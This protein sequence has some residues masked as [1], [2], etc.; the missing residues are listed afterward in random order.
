MKKKKPFKVCIFKGFIK[1]KT[2][3]FKN[4][5]TKRCNMLTTIVLFIFIAI[6]NY[7]KI[8]GIRLVKRGRSHGVFVILTAKMFF[9]FSI[10]ELV[11]FWFKPAL[12]Y[13]LPLVLITFLFYIYMDR[14][15]LAQGI[16]GKHSEV[17]SAT[18]DMATSVIPPAT[19][20]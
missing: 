1:G 17:N 3:D 13:V 18:E 7:M 19:S 8:D 12:F 6:T 2:N 4:P 15:I 5:I 14:K 9:W 10:V 16:S 20:I 11:Y